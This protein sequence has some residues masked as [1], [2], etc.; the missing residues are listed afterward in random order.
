MMMLTNTH[1]LTYAI[2]TLWGA[3]AWFDALIFELAAAAATAVVGC[4]DWVRGVGA[5]LFAALDL[6][7]EKA[8]QRTLTNWLVGESLQWDK[9]RP[10]V[11]E[12]VIDAMP[13]MILGVA[14]LVLV[15]CL[16][17][18]LS[19]FGDVAAYIWNS[20]GVAAEA[21]YWGIC[22]RFGYIPPGVRDDMEQLFVAEALNEDDTE[23]LI[24]AR[25]TVLPRDDDVSSDESEAS[26]EEDDE[27]DDDK[28]IDALIFEQRVLD[29]ARRD[30]WI[31]HISSVVRIRFGAAV[32]SDAATQNRVLRLC[33]EAFDT[34]VR[35]N[36]AVLK[37][38][39]RRRAD[40]GTHIAPGPWRMKVV[41]MAY[42]AVNQPDWLAAYVEAE[43]LT[44][45]SR[46]NAAKLAFLVDNHVDC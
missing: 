24:A 28:R 10:S 27:A 4:A 3:K 37:V 39:H 19:S 13:F 26:D 18:Y 7:E 45:A 21:R 34:M 17:C 36:A 35:E 5:A 23:Q 9:V 31:E 29:L 15:L 43:K 20:M 42:R 46:R 1:I 33:E 6:S 25:N 12:A 30:Y 8:I 16:A 22:R 2:A 44:L 32:P 38:L 11:S 41:R 40:I 14:A